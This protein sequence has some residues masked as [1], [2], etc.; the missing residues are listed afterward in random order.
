[1]F[2]AAVQQSRFRSPIHCRYTTLLWTGRR[3]CRRSLSFCL[4]CRLIAP[5]SYDALAASQ[6]AATNLEHSWRQPLPYGS[7]NNE[8]RAPR[9]TSTVTHLPAKFSLT[10]QLPY[11]SKYTSPSVLCRTHTKETAWLVAQHFVWPGVEKE[12]RTGTRALQSFRRAVTPVGNFTLPVDH[13]FSPSRRSHG[14]SSDVS[15]LYILPYSSRPLHS[16]AGSLHPGQHS[17]HRG[18]CPTCRLDI[19]LWF[20]RKPSPQT[21][22]AS[23]SHNSSAP[24]Q[25]CVELVS[26]GQQP[27][28]PQPTDPWNVFTGL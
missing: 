6:E 27:T 10:F 14:A 9:S 17:L 16:L 22:D 7:R 21:R 3:C 13:F 26:P 20:A 2:N 28:I 12:F 4:S 1:M 11:S 8:F 24:W 19:P 23:L 18:T 15:G 25:S 5:P